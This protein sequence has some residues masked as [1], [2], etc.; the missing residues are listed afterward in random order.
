MH[1][2][3]IIPH[4]MYLFFHSLFWKFIF[5]FYLS[6]L[7]QSIF[8]LFIVFFYHFLILLYS[9]FCVFIRFLVRTLLFQHSS[10][11]FIYCVLLVL[12]TFTISVTRVISIII[13]LFLYHMVRDFIYTYN[14]H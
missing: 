7:L 6:S 8:Y 3:K 11:Y 2:S 14:P 1:S 9:L 13:F 10:D 4:Q 5:Y 12:I